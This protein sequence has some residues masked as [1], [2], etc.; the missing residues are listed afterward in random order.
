VDDCGKK[1]AQGLRV[2]GSKRKKGLLHIEPARARRT[3]RIEA[4]KT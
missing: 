4:E 1:S 3:Q 2:Y